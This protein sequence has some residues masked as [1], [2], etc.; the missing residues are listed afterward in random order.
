MIGP[1]GTQGAP[2][3]SGLERVVREEVIAPGGFANYTIDCPSGKKVLGVSA[4]FNVIGHPTSTQ[5]RP[6]LDG[7]GVYGRN[8]SAGDLTF[9]V[10]IACAYVS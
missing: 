1:A 4:F 8:T 9:I 3:I 7:G 2:A 10:A 6:L 5:L